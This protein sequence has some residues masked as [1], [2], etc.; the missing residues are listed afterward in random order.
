MPYYVVVRRVATDRATPSSPL[1]HTADVEVRHQWPPDFRPPASG[2]LALIQPWEFGAIPSAWIEPLQSVVDELWVPSE[3]VRAM[4]LDAGLAPDRVAVVPNGV[5]LE[6][7]APEGEAYDLS[8]APGVRFL[9]V[10]GAIARKGIDLLLSAY[11]DAF[12]G[13]DD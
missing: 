9:F 12:A 8:D 11:A 2:H 3:H 4:Y 1:P 13:R 7:C 10:G 6:R 5:D